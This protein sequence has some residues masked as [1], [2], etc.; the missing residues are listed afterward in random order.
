MIYINKKDSLPD[1]DIDFKID[2]TRVIKEIK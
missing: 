2:K 1:I